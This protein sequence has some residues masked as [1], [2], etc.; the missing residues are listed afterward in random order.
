M[1]S[2]TSEIHPGKCPLTRPWE[3]APDPTLAAS[4]GSRSKANIYRDGYPNQA[5]R[6]AS[7]IPGMH[8]L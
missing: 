7:D 3:E 8:V 6:P 5:G 4:T 2:H 1:G